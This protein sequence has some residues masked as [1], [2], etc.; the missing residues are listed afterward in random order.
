MSRSYS[1]FFFFD[2]KKNKY[3]HDYWIWNEFGGFVG[4]VDEWFNWIVHRKIIRE[5]ETDVNLSKWW[6]DEGRACGWARLGGIWH[7]KAETWIRVKAKWPTTSVYSKENAS[8]F[9][10]LFS[11]FPLWSVSSL[12]ILMCKMGMFYFVSLWTN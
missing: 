5:R 6:L 11:S 10:M 9:A 2:L 7:E 4:L 8:F 12:I 3:F 1:F